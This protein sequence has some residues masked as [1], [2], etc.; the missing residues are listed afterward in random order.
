L[1]QE[2]VTRGANLAGA[3]RVVAVVA[4]QHVQWW[5][6]DVSSLSPQNVVVQPANRG[7][8]AGI[9]LPLLRIARQ[10]R[11]ARIVA[12][13]S[14]HFIQD[15]AVLAQAIERAL[16]AV[17]REPEALM[18]LGITP[19]RP[20][21]ELGWILPVA[22][23]RDRVSRV[24]RFVEKPPVAVAGELQ[25]G[26]GLW[27]SFILVG[28]AQ[29]L[30]AMYRMALPSLVQ[31]L[32]RAT[33]C[34]G[35]G[36]ARDAVANAYETLETH[37]FSRDLLERNVEKLRVVPVAACGWSDLGTP[38]RLARCA[39]DLPLFVPNLSGT[40]APRPVLATVV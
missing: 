13:P 11:E 10:D 6:D 15:E 12:L 19:E 30:L 23:S 18:L 22:G 7:T 36:A 17:E 27:N 28:R 32:A 20:D 39:A 4:A 9:L 14:D 21:P 8:A 5:R 29:A 38:E 16:A 34:Q 35:W 25:R 3:R 26:G 24:A 37:D 31:R 1:L 2:T 40:I 33:A